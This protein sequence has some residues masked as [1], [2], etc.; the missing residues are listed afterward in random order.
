MKK[1]FAIVLAMALVFSAMGTVTAFAA[2]TTTTEG[3]AE[4]IQVNVT[5]RASN[6]VSGSMNGGTTVYDIPL[7]AGTNPTFEFSI[8]GNSALYVDVVAVS[9]I[10]NEFTL[11]SNICC[12]GTTHTKY[13]FSLVSGTYYLTIRVNHGSSAG[14]EK[15]YTFTANW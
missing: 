10:G 11:F 3:T 6:S 15:P 9:P 13:H 8:S 1:I 12:D 7:T 5:P 14:Q 4:E 2:E